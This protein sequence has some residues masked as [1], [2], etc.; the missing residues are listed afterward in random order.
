MPLFRKPILE[1]ALVLCWS[2]GFI[3]AVLASETSSIYL[4]RVDKLDSQII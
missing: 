3:G 2:S 1:G 4:G